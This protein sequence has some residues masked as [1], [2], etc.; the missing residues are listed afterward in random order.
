VKEL[1]AVIAVG[2]GHGAA[3]EPHGDV[4]VVVDLR[5]LV[6][7]SDLPG[8]VEQ[9]Q[10]EDVQG[11]AEAIDELDAS[12]DEDRAH[13]QRAEDAPEQD[14]ELILTRNCEEREDDRPYEDIVDRE[15]LLDEETRV[16]LA[17]HH[18]A[19]P[20]G[21]QHAEG[22]PDGDPHRRFHRSLAE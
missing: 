12:E 14:A 5:T 15:A 8:R 20:H 17:R 22:E 9:E 21:Q 1:L 7:M 10:A 16:V 11:P 18:T 6:V 2:G 13:D 4:R 19:L 3:H